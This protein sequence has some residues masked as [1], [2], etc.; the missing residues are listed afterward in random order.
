MYCLAVCQFSH[1]KRWW[2]QAPGIPS[3][4]VHRSGIKYQSA[5]VL[6]V[7]SNL[8]LGHARDGLYLEMT[9]QDS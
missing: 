5:A 4:A 7:T 8:A 9:Q 6:Y 2:C 1:S 3:S